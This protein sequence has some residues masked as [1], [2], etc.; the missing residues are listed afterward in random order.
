MNIYGQDITERK[1]AEEEIRRLNAE[2]EQRVAERT[3]ALE[4]ANT[5]LEAFS[6]SVSHDLRAPLRRIDGFSQMLLED[7]DERL[8]STGRD[9]LQR[10]R[11]A[12]Q[13]MGQLID[14][15]LALS[16][17]TRAD[18]VAQDVDLSALA[19]SIGAALENAQPDRQVDLIVA[20]G[21]VARGDSHLLRIALENLLDNAWKFTS[22]HP[23]ARIEFG[24][25]EMAGETVYFVRDDGAG[26]DM[27]YADKLF[28][29]FQRLHTGSE[30]EG[31]GVGLVTV[32]RIIQRHGGRVWA[33]GVPERGATFYF[34]LQK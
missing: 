17:L 12:C 25:A 21:L 29:A 9:Y 3:T 14:D 7:Y 32:K 34:T 23:R 31:N 20:D 15:M 1:R 11:A 22:T 26:F 24:A 10:I 33:E 4:A 5:E 19:L 6:Y 28:E 27:A 8:D 30:F 2:L 16:R 13:R 18:M